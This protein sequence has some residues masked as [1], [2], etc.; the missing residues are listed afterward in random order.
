[1]ESF[2]LSAFIAFRSYLPAL[3]EIEKNKGV[4]CDP[5]AVEVCLGLFWEKGF[6]SE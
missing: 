3:E 4:L 5:A 1:M 2:S 6:K